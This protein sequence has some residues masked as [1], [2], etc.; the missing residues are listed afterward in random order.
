MYQSETGYIVTY[1]TAE[2]L[3]VGLTTYRFLRD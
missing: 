3:N 1:L 2:K